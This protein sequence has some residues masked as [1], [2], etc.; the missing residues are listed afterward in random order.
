MTDKEIST[1]PGP[2]STWGQ[3][4]LRTHEQ[5]TSRMTQNPLRGLAVPSEYSLLIIYIASGFFDLF[6]PRLH[7]ESWLTA[8]VARRTALSLG[9]QRKEQRRDA[10]KTFTI[11]LFQGFTVVHCLYWICSWIFSSATVLSEPA[12]YI[13]LTFQVPNF[14]S[15]FFR[16]GRLFKESVQVRGF[17]WSFVTSL[18]FTVRSC[19][20]T[21]NPQARESPLVGYSRL[22]IQYP[23]YLE[24]VSSIRNLR[25]AMPLRQG[26]QR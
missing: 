23:P 9:T 1:L 24:A 18:F 8:S 7:K 22:L 11:Y 10:V 5:L 15:I 25:R 20:P 16:L 2:R 19:S 13:L 21:T 4:M 26:T 17:S 6:L 12:L 3:W 14:M